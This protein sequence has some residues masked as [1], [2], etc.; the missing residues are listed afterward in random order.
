MK[1][2]KQFAFAQHDTV[3]SKYKKTQIASFSL[4]DGCNASLRS[5][6]F[7]FPLF[8]PISSVFSCSPMHQHHIHPLLLQL[9]LTENEVSVFFAGFKLGPSTVIQ[10]ATETKLQRITTHAIIE[11]LLY[12]GLFLATTSKQK[13]LVYPND[14]KSLFTLLDKKKQELTE[15]EDGLHKASQ[16][17]NNLQA[18]SQGFAHVR[19][20]K[21]KEGVQLMIDEI[22]RDAQDMYILCDS[23]HFYDLIDNQFLERSLAIRK[24]HN[25]TVKMLFPMGFEH[26]CYTQGTYEQALSIRALPDTPALI[27]ALNLRGNKIGFHCEHQGFITTTIIED[28][29]IRQIMRFLFEH[30]W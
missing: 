9:G 30:V 16:F 20:Y 11:R 24:K 19:Y 6:F 29:H 22:I 27:G 8:L 12:K 26:F 4:R 1:K 2:A 13:R 28:A 25:L 21:G 14:T 5:Y 23:R 10:L 18:R 15:L 17:L 7:L 3:T